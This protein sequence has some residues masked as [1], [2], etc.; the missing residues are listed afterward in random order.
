[1]YDIKQIYNK[2]FYRGDI[3]IIIIIIILETVRPEMPISLQ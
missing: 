3:I 1:M 2:A